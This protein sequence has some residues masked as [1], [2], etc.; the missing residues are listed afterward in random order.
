[1]EKKVAEIFMQ[2]DHARRRADTTWSGVFDLEAVVA[3]CKR[4]TEE[5]AH[6]YAQL[7]EATSAEVARSF[8]DAR[9]LPQV[10]E[11]LIH[12]ST[13]LGPAG[14]TA[15]VVGKALDFGMC[16]MIGAY[17]EPAGKVAVF[18]TEKDAELWLAANG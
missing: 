10:V 16:R 8:E 6:G 4:R 1:M 11:R 2:V 15:V 12:Q 14:P 18:Y 5:G 3:S 13:E 9:R 17:F 7:I